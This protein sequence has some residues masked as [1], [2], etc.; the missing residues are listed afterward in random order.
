[1]DF[2]ELVT[3]VFEV[4][5]VGA[6][7]VGFIIA[8]VLSAQL[9]WR[10]RDGERAFRMLRE[11]IGSVILLGLEILVAADLVKTVTSTPSLTD[12]AV[13]AIIVVIRTLLSFSLQIE[14]EGTLPWRRLATTGPQQFGRA[15][16][17]GGERTQRLAEEQ[18]AAPPSTPASGTQ[19]PT[20]Q[21]PAQQADGTYAGQTPQPAAGANA[22]PAIA[23]PIPDDEAGFPELRSRS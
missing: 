6:M 13:L 3:T 16:K 18:D 19:F 23:P 8:I 10:T 9:L 2:F 17:R 21:A 22:G 1:M 4:A 14:I 20:Q 12:A 15:V 5:G 7:V 11:T